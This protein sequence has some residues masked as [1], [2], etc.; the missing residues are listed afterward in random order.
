MI[1]CKY[2]GQ[3]HYAWQQ[4]E[5][6]GKQLIRLANLQWRISVDVQREDD[7]IKMLEALTNPA[8]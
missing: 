5:C 2:C 7:K 3:I 1:K 6:L 4:S 8:P